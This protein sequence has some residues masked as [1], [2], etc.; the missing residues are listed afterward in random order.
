MSISTESTASEPE[1]DEEALKIDSCAYAPRF[2]AF[3][4]SVH[5][6][7]TFSA[8]APLEAENMAF[9]RLRQSSSKLGRRASS[10][11]LCA[12]VLMITSSLYCLSGVGAFLSFREKGHENSILDPRF[13]RTGGK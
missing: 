13:L 1:E 6:A 3:L 7:G 2:A 11:T 4:A 5:S 12:L 8:W 10:L 9:V